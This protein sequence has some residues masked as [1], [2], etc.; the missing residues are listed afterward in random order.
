[1]SF[2][3]APLAVAVVLAGVAPAAAQSASVSAGGGEV[4]G[5]VTLPGASSVEDSRART[6][7]APSIAAP[8]TRSSRSPGGQSV[9]VRSP[10]GQ[11]SAGAW[12]SGPGE[13]VVSGS[14]SPGS[15]VVVTPDPDAPPCPRGAD[16]EYR[17]RTGCSPPPTAATP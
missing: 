15:T 2:L 11:A 3:P 16:A 5:S 10:D 9:T 13:T 1:M 6:T 14:G 17:S 8:P 7:T 12:T 4:R